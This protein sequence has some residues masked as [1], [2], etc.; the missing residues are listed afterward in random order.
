M[1]HP[2]S[3]LKQCTSD[4]Y[5]IIPKSTL[6][7]PFSHIVFRSFDCTGRTLELKVFTLEQE[8]ALADYIIKCSKMFHGL[9][10]KQTRKLAWQ[11]AK[12]NLNTYPAQWDTNQEAGQDWF[13]GLIKRNPELS[14]RTP[15][16]TSIAR[17]TAFNRQNVNVF[18]EQ[19]QDILSRPNFKLEPHRLWNLDETGVKTVADTTKVIS[20]KCL[21]QVG[22]ISSAERGVLVTMCCCVNA[23][24]TSLPPVYVFPR[25]NFKNHMLNEAPNGSLGLANPSGW[26]NSNLFPEVLR[27]FIK[28]MNVSKDHPALLVMDN[29]ESH[30]GIDTIDL[31]RDNGLI[32]LA[33]PPHCSHKLQPL[34]VSVYG[35]FKRYYSSACNDRM[36]SHPGR[37]ITIYDVASLSAQAYYK[38]FTPSNIIAGFNRSGIYPVNKDIFPDEVFL[39]AAPTDRPMQDQSQQTNEPQPS[40]S[41]KPEPSTSAQLEP[42]TNSQSTKTVQPHSLTT[43]VGQGTLSPEMIRPF[44]KAPERKRTNSRKRAKSTIITD[45]PERERIIAEKTPKTGKKVS[46]GLFEDDEET[47]TESMDSYDSSSPEQSDDSDIVFQEKDPDPGDYVLVKYARKSRVVH[48]IGVIKQPKDRDGDY[49]VQFLR[50]STRHTTAFAFVEPLVEDISSVE[51]DS[52]LGVLPVPIKQTTKRLQ[53]IIQFN[54]NFDGYNIE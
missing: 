28:H 44:P 33:F 25:V 46:R 11:Y 14:L 48:Y 53:G 49:E 34:D 20:Q 15:E 13:Y 41:D 8:R 50:R 39:S 22:Q 12:A 2:S 30:L 26:M 38:A 1:D 18:F 40:T 36:L 35:P 52:V 47:E 3:F 43:D 45:T 29:H 6:F 9:S 4:I 24:G 42:A 32:I 21:K 37:A 23:V 5:P 31:A 17:A 16:A 51:S 54:V 27:H 19:Y 7:D 10:V